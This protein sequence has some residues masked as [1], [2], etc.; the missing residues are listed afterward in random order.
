VIP[1]AKELRIAEIVV[2]RIIWRNVSAIFCVTIPETVILAFGGHCCSRSSIRSHST[3][4]ACETPSPSRRPKVVQ[5]AY[6]TPAASGLRQISLKDLR[7]LAIE[8][9]G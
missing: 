1:L 8:A 3:R 6:K 4:F 9:T 2:F 5:A 7:H